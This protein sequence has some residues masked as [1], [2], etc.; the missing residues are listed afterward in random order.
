[1]NQIIVLETCGKGESVDYATV[2]LFENV[3][4]AQAFCK[5]K[6]TG[7]IKYWADAQ[8]VESG[9][10]IELMQPCEE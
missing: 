1:M 7:R 3:E 2:H 6:R 9:E 4:D 5:S 10:T 8:I